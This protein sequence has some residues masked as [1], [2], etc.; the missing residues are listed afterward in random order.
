MDQQITDLREIEKAIKAR[1]IEPGDL[2]A[3]DFCA[4][5]FTLTRG[6]RVLSVP[7]QPGEAWVFRDEHTPSKKILYI[8]EGCTI[9]LMKKGGEDEKAQ[10][11]RHPK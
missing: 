5:G 3:I 1:T 9:T 10:E 8:T 6:A 2:V 11:I 4:A 7:T